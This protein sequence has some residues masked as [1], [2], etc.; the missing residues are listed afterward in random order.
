MTNK[1]FTIYHI[2]GVK[3]GCTTNLRKRLREQ[4][5]LDTEWEVLETHTDNQVA[6]KRETELQ[7]QY[8]YPLDRSVYNFKTRS[9]VGSMG[10]K[11]NKESGFI[12]KVGKIQGPIQG[13]KNIKSGVLA[14]GRQR[15]K[16]LH[17]KL[18]L[19][20]KKDTGDFVGEF[21]SQNEAARQL[22]LDVGSISQVIRGKL[23]HT[24]GY[25]FQ[26]AT[27]KG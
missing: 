24:G 2:P 13:Q 5:L 10:G 19:A 25:T 23:N 22:R 12:S 9:R 16:E 17:S 8:G 4:G 21:E 1:I 18:V 11:K 15:T 6:S 3:I 14:K 7:I 27:T 20:F 26:L